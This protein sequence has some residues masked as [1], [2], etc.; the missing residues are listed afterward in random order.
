MN[1]GITLLIAENMMQMT[2]LQKSIGY[3]IIKETN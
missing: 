1:V 2:R 3:C